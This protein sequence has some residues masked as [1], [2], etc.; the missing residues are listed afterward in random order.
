MTNNMPSWGLVPSEF[1]AWLHYFVDG[2]DNIIA[3]GLVQSSVGSLGGLL[4]G[5]REILRTVLRRRSRL[6]RR[7]LR[8]LD[9]ARGD[10][11]GAAWENFAC[12]GVRVGLHQD[13]FEIQAP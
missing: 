2:A 12:L 5:R 1:L 10:V 7:S 9:W 3:R 4:R 6:L 11:S 8:R 13:E